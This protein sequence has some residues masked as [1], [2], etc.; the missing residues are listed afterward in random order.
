[1]FFHFK[2]EL[3]W[4]GSA[5]LKCSAYKPSTELIRSELGLAFVYILTLCLWFFDDDDPLTSDEPFV[6]LVSVLFSLLLKVNTL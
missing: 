3:K 4:K 5:V 1:M 2:F 6:H